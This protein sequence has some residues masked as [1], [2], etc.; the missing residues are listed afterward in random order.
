MNNGTLHEDI[1]TFI[2]ISRSV[3]LKMRDVPD[4]RCTG[5]QNTHFY[6]QTRFTEN[7]SGYKMM[8]KNVVEPDRPHMTI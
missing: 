3:L 1:C 8:W 5:N 4:K 7:R 6:V 2:I